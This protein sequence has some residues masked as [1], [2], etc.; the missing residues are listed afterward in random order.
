MQTR[1]I[2]NT[3]E[4]QKSILCLEKR[5]VNV[6]F[7]Y[8]VWVDKNFHLKLLSPKGSF[9]KWKIAFIY[10]NP[11]SYSLCRWRSKLKY[12]LLCNEDIIKMWSHKRESDYNHC[13]RCPVYSAD[14]ITS[15]KTKLWYMPLLPMAD[16]NFD[17]SWEVT[18]SRLY[19]WTIWCQYCLLAWKSPSVLSTKIHPITIKDVDENNLQYK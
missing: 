8:A 3:A 18:S 13:N 4:F 17:V 6:F 7:R 9:Y 5:V 19:L 2:Q 16:D 14:C 12:I 1:C 10:W 11:I 15:C